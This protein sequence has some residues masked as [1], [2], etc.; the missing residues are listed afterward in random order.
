M[1]AAITVWI[2]GGGCYGSGYVRQLRKARDR[3]RLPPSRWV[4]LDRDPMCRAWLNR[5]STDPLEL[6]Q[7]AWVESLTAICAAGELQADDQLVP[8][9]FQST[10]ITDWL[11]R[12]A[13]AAGRQ[14]TPT[15]LPPIRRGL[16]FESEVAAH[17]RYAS[18]ADWQCPVHC[19]EPPTC[20]ATRAPK[21]WDM[22]ATLA[23]MASHQG[24]HLLAFPCLHW[25]FGVGTVPGAALLQAREH[26]RTG[27]PGPV[28]VASLST[29]HAAVS[30]WVL[31]KA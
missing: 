24:A 11:A 13:V 15:A 2:V 7:D 31:T 8:S 4:I 10:L 21:T 1:S 16:R 17:F 22:R 29:C 6:R 26:V 5:Q 9:P 14:I 23:D 28:L 25:Y 3:G 30:A 18:F 20:P 19:I 27:A 12:E